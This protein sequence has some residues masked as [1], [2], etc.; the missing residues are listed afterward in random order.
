MTWR[1]RRIGKNAGSVESFVI[2]ESVG[3]GTCRLPSKR[4]KWKSDWRGPV[5]ADR[6]A[7]LLQR[8][9]AADARLSL[10]ADL[11]RRTAPGCRRLDNVCRS[12]FLQHLIP[13]HCITAE[14]F[15]FIDSREQQPNN[16]GVIAVLQRTEAFWADCRVNGEDDC[17]C[18]FLFVQKVQPKPPSDEFLHNKLLQLAFCPSFKRA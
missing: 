14:A 4:W 15:I 11:F 9:S 6:E 1:L 2:I 10:S 13:P 5:R 7:A 8:H 18:W 12:T 16:L 3:G 17:R